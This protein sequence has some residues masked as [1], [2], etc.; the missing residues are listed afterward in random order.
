M[1]TKE[2]VADRSENQCELC[3]TT[4]Q[5]EVCAVLDA[6][7][8]LNAGDHAMLC[9]TCKQEVANPQTLTE[10][11]WFC[12]NNSMWSTVPGVQVLAWRQLNYLAKQFSWAQDLLDQLYLDDDTLLWAK[13]G[14]IEL[15]EA[16][17]ITRDSNG[18]VLANG[19]SVTL[20]KDLEVK[21]AGFT[22]KRVIPSSFPAKA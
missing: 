21:G 6:P 12:L 10:S 16:S 1:N 13:S 4:E 3:G 19:D 22:A 2:I 20:I 17:V 5:L 8:L 14:L 9:F 15:G 11:H 18:N 7:N